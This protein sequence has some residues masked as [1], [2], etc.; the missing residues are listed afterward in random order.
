MYSIDVDERIPEGAPAHELGHVL[1]HQHSDLETLA[2]PWRVFYMPTDPF[3]DQRY[4]ILD[5]PKQRGLTR[6]QNHSDQGC[7]R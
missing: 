4:L 5:I 3:T 2:Q 7:R 6:L 1:A